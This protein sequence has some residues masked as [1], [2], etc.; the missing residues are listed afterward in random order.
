MHACI[1]GRSWQ[2]A[3]GRDFAVDISLTPVLEAA[4]PYQPAPPVLVGAVMVTLVATPAA[5][6]AVIVGALGGLH[7][8]RMCIQ[9]SGRDPTL[10]SDSGQTH[11]LASGAQQHPCSAPTTPFERLA[12]CKHLPDGSCEG[13]KFTGGPHPNRVDSIRVET[14]RLPFGVLP[15][16]KSKDKL[17]VSNAPHAYTHSGEY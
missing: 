1:H 2:R 10:V 11:T 14:V 13:G 12:N 17:Q 8:G 15:R 6:T 4:L 5:A 9:V 7:S 3:Q 16:G